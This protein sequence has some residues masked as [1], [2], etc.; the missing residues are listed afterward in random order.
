MPKTTRKKVTHYSENSKPRM[1]NIKKKNRKNWP[2]KIYSTV[3][4]KSIIDSKFASCLVVAKITE[5]Q[6]TFYQ[7]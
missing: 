6:I 7:N 2:L 1:V 4:L 3:T 5:L